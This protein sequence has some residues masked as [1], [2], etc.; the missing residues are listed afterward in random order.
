VVVGNTVEKIV[1]DPTKDVLLEVYAP[2]CG[3]CKVGAAK[4][5]CLVLHGGVVRAVVQPL[6]GGS[7]RAAGILGR[8]H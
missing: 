1:Q 6:Q 4:G 8:W 3:H 7:A 2:W 5:W